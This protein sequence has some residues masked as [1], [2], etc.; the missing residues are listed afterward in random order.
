MKIKNLIFVLTLLIFST[1]S[2]SASEKISII[3]SVKP[4]HSIVDAIATNSDQVELLV[5]TN[6]S[7]HDYQLKPSQLKAMQNAN[8]IFYFDD[9][10]ETFMSSAFDILPPKVR[11]SSI[12]EKAN[13]NLLQ[14]RESG[15][16]D[17]HLHEGD[18]GH[19]DHDA[20][21]DEDDD[22]HDAH[23]DEHDD[24]HDD[25]DAHKDEHDDD[26]N[27]HVWLD[28]EN[29]KSIVNYVVKELTFINPKNHEIYEENGKRYIEKL[30]NLDAELK[31][32]L[33]GLQDKPFIVFHDA[34]QYFERAFNL[35]A[36]GSISLRDDIH[37]VSPNR[38][39][40][41]KDKIK[42]TNAECVFREPQFSDRLINTIAEKA[43]IKVGTLDPLGASLQ[44]DKGLYFTL[45]R[46]LADNFKKCLTH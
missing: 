40:E 31:I 26:V 4:L 29:A 33:S 8:I 18:D 37:S 22:G 5:T 12:I 19:D 17:K 13:L 43:D 21:K 44:N 6:Q 11:K 10:F 46:E 28:P 34:Y 36:V 9:N 14:Y 2:I 16:W 32:S 15:A 30:N 39:K 42:K 38:I 41:I 24:G 7:P 35:N 1:S 45:M 25:H 27:L 23:K 20:H 3:T